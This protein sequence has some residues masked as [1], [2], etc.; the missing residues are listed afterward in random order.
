MAYMADH[1][2]V[3]GGIIYTLSKVTFIF[4]IAIKNIPGKGKKI[5]EA[6]HNTIQPSGVIF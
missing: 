1:T 3:S 6:D 2:M 5:K 4:G